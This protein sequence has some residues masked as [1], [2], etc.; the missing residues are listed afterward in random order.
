MQRRRFLRP[1]ERY[2]RRGLQLVHVDEGG[3]APS[4]TRRCRYAPKG[5]RVDGLTSGHS[6]PRT[7]LIAAR[8][9][10]DCEEPFLFEGTY[11]GAVF[12]AWL[13]VRLCPCLT[14][15]HLVILDNGAFR[16]S[17]EAAQRI[18]HAGTTLLFL[19]P[20]SPDPNPIEH[21][22]AA[23]KKHRAY[24]DTATVHVGQSSSQSLPR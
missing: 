5:Q 11:D 10:P 8:I 17:P 18:E 4:V 12:N 20:Y 6:R 1:R 9:G 14:R 23:L 22:F 2:I 21:D 24:Q 7:S 15:E 16:K 19:R 3:F 13:K